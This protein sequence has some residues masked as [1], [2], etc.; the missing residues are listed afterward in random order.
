MGHR[1]AVI[2]LN[3]SLAVRAGFNVEPRHLVD[4]DTAKLEQNK[5]YLLSVNLNL[6]IV[7]VPLLQ[8]AVGH[9]LLV[10]NNPGRIDLPAFFRQ[11]SG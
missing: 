3:S 7:E 9:V 8:R 10:V 1:W 4:A 5:V 6:E 2:S 11:S